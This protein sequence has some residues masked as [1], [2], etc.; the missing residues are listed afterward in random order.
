MA[1][2]TAALRQ[3]GSPASLQPGESGAAAPH[4]RPTGPRLPGWVERCPPRP[5]GRP[6]TTPA[7][8]HPPRGAACAP[9]PRPV[10]AGPVDARRPPVPAGP[11]RVPGRSPLSAAGPAALSGPQAAPRGVKWG[12]PGTRLAAAASSLALGPRVLGSLSLAPPQEACRAPVRP[13]E[14]R[15]IQRGSERRWRARARARVCVCMCMCVCASFSIF[16]FCFFTKAAPSNFRSSCSDPR[17]FPSGL[18]PGGRGFPLL[19]PCWKEK[20]T[21]S[22]MTTLRAQNFLLPLTLYAPLDG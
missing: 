22:S 3:D 9:L 4:A 8:C 16:A 17:P 20:L 21:F 18:S 15:A 10:A 13:P 12:P 5:R 19:P 2:G 7:C 11:G 1:A 14:F 6:G